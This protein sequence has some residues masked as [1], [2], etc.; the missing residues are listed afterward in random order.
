MANG[1]S[2]YLS[3]RETVQEVTPYKMQAWIAGHRA[4]FASPWT[5]NQRAEGIDVEGTDMLPEINATDFKI[6]HSHVFAL[7]PLWKSAVCS[8][9]QHVVE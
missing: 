5:V 9:I 6:K 4:H 3:S 1:K 8:S 7:I 2:N